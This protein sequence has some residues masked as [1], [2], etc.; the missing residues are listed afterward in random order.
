MNTHMPLF[1]IALAAGSFLGALSAYA[2]PLNITVTT[3]QE[4]ATPAV[5]AYNLGHFMQGSNA[6][7]WWRYT[8]P[9]GARAFITPSA[10]DAASGNAGN[11]TDLESF[12][13]R[14]ELVRANVSNPARP[15]NTDYINLPYFEDRYKNSQ[16]T[17]NRFVV[18]PTFTELRR[19]GVD[20]LINSSASITR[21]VITGNDDWAGK[22]M[23]WQ[24]YYTHAFYFARDFDVHRHGMF[25]EPNLASGVTVEEWQMR[26]ELASDAIQCGIADVNARYG[27]NLVPEI[28]A[29]NVSGIDAGLMNTWGIPSAQNIHRRY[30]GTID[31]EW[32]NFHVYNYQRYARNA[33]EYVTSVTT[34]RNTF[35][36]ILAGETP[37]E[38]VPTEF[39]TWTARLWDQVPETADHSLH[40]S[41]LGCV[42]IGLTNVRTPQMYLFK[43]AMSSYDGVNYPIQ[44]NGTHY[45]NNDTASGS[46][47]SYGGAAQTAEVYR[48]FIKASKAARPYFKCTGDSYT[49]TSE[50]TQRYML[51]TRDEANGFVHIFAASRNSANV[52]V[53]FDLSVFNI[54]EG[55]LYTVEEVS[56]RS[57]GGVVARGTTAANGIITATLPGSAVTLITIP[58]KPQA[59]MGDGGS[60][61]LE[62]NAAAAAQLADGA[63]KSVPNGAGDSIIVR[64]DGLTADGRQV[65]LIKIPMPAIAPGDIQV[66]LLDIFA[67]TTNS[68]TWAHTHVYGLEDDNWDEGTVTWASLTSGLKQNVAVGNKINNNVIANQGSLTKILGQLIVTSTT[69]SEKMVNVTDF[70]RAQTDGFASFLIVQDFRWD[71]TL[72]VTSPSPGD[73]NVSGDEEPLIPGDTQNCGISIV[74]REG[75][76]GVLKGPRLLVAA[77]MPP[78]GPTLTAQ[79]MST[80]V[81]EG[82]PV[83]LSVGL[84]NTAG[85][86]YEWYK[87][88]QKITG[89][90]SATL[91]LPGALADA[92][93]YYVI[94]TNG[95]GN[96]TSQDAI[97][98]IKPATTP[99]SPFT[100]PVGIA[101]DAAN[102]IYVSD[103]S[104][105]II[106]SVAPT[107][108]V[109]TFV[110]SFGTA[111]ARN[112]VGTVAQFRN[113][114]GLTVCGGKLYVADTGNAV[115]RSVSGDATVLSYAG[116]VGVHAH[117][118]GLGAAARF[119]HP[120][121][122]ASDAEGNIYVADTENH[123]IRK[124]AVSGA[125]TTIAG[126]PGIYG[127]RDDL[128]TQALFSLPAGIAVMGTGEN[129]VVYV[130]D[131]GNHT[132][133]KISANGQVTTFAGAPATPGSSDGPS[134]SARFREPRGMVVDGDG[135]IY[136]ADTGNSLIRAISGGTVT[137]IAGLSGS[138][139]V[140]GLAAYKDG[141]GES[142]W[143]SNPESLALGADGKLYIA[144]TGNGVIR[145]IDLDD[146]VT[147]LPASTKPQPPPI[148]DFYNH[149]N[150]SSGGGGAPSFW[151]LAAIAAL[152]L[153]RRFR[154]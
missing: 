78:S 147:T 49:I 22:W 151:M 85:A 100:Q 82:T 77:T 122:V 66:A 63:L 46:L 58:T 99:V 117:A 124:I 56:D 94:V 127:A 36:A 60:R 137:T 24:Y 42:L 71:I 149:G 130:A 44:K 86:S 32:R 81:N 28:V 4:G 68:G 59:S 103:Y 26:L 29:P 123:T 126:T 109:S 145:V 61:I 72:G 1:R 113:P 92:G 93:V 141:K 131:T 135:T 48:L 146:N 101:V 3:E 10:A 89:A 104:Q 11:V 7:D 144:D 75:G 14:R 80:Q 19:Q 18:V 111:G 34:S 52:D 12:N 47:N 64:S 148:D 121:G 142:A 27:K 35:N 30:D 74:S 54:P 65:T 120:E 8:G 13:A 33:N 132:I 53:N 128:G 62:I 152:I 136:L 91:T 98:V 134:L 25:N 84:E 67:A 140:P 17:D 154:R 114:T 21:F 15:I 88:G 2:A 70:V 6:A 102:N 125:I 37:V 90:S 51:V 129:L 153:S 41:S 50:S 9:N 143:F 138:D 20:I 23:L 118:D 115:I 133:R 69:P 108:Y 73:P 106:R 107:N 95:S 55:N 39:N 150:G 38:F 87:D 96:A 119:N 110:G 112:A 116:G 45:V 31:P 79:P 83:T 76:S 43:F 40:F 16:M 97:V 139:A 5:L 57:R 105:H